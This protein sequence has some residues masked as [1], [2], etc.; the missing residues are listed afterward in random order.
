MV[1][2]EEVAKFAEPLPNVIVSK[3]HPFMCS[4][5]GQKMIA[6]DIQ[7][8]NLNRIVVGACTPKIHEPTYRAVL[9]SAGLSKYYFEMVNL[10]EHVSFV[11]QDAPE[12]ATEKAKHL[13]KGG[14]YRA[15]LLEKVPIKEVDVEPA[16]LVIGGGI[17][18]ISASLAVANAG[19]KVYLVEKDPSIGGNMAQLDRIFPTDDCSI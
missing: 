11:T 12:S 1:N 10:R 6:E 4:D 19:I 2:V 3:T 14:V 15:A 17:G 13:I 18:G 9:E 5:P 16:V 8:Y 7:K